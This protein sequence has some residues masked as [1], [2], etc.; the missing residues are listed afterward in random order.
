MVLY[1]VRVSVFQQHTSPQRFE[2]CPPPLPRGKQIYSRHL[3]F[4]ST[5]MYKV[6][7]QFQKK[8]V[9]SFKTTR[10]KQ[11]KEY[12]ITFQVQYEE[13]NHATKN[14]SFDTKLWRF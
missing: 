7:H 9:R 12:K 13:G 6:L 14:V 3:F 4:H 8:K 2:E 11:L 1:R 10:Y 5:C